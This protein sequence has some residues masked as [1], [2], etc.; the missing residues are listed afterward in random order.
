MTDITLKDITIGIISDT[1]GYLRQHALTALKE[2][3]LIIHAGDIGAP[4]ILAELRVIAPV[5]AVRGNTDR[6]PWAQDLPETATT[7]VG[8]TLFY[9]VH[10]LGRL[11]L[12]PAAAGFQV[13]VHGHSHQPSI[14]QAGEVLYLNPGSAGPQRFRLPITLALLHF[15]AARF[16]PEIVEL[17]VGL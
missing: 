1:H 16:C 11:D 13:V 7:E 14:H 5:I 10:D 3:D 8:G 2:A 17:D 12:D 4:Q 15:R 6:S 9:V